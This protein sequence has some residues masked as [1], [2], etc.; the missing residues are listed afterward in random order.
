LQVG[1]V[2]PDVG[3]LD[4]F[5]EAVG[6]AVELGGA[7][8]AAEGDFADVVGAG[9]EGRVDVDEVDG[10]AVAVGE[11]VGEDLF[12]VTVEELAGGRGGE[13][14][15]GGVEV[16]DVLG[17]KRGDGTEGFFADPVEQGATFGGGD[18]HLGGRLGHGGSGRGNGRG[19]DLGSGGGFGSGLFLGRLGGAGGFQSGFFLGGHGRRR[20]RVGED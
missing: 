17:G 11:E 14:G 19:R 1:I 9:V 5:A 12:V 16:L 7:G 10:A 3:V 15:G 2:G 20:K 6:L 8:L 13:I 4:L 18:L